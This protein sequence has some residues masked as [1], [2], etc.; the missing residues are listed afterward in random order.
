MA[1]PLTKNEMGLV[2]AL[3]Q[4]AEFLRERADNLRAL[5]ILNAGASA[6]FPVALANR[7]YAE[8]SK[9]DGEAFALLGEA[10]ELRRRQDAARREQL[11]QEAARALSTDDLLDLLTEA[12]AAGDEAQVAMCRR[13]L[14]GDEDALNACRDAVEEAQKGK[15]SNE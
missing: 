8:A 7:Y 14:V 1:S 10:H 11:A 12:A 3:E 9:L 13:A 2:D 15:G 4:R 6:D 5:V